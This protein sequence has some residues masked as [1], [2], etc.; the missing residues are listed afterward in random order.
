MAYN[1]R[2]LLERIIEIQDIVLAEKKRLIFQKTIYRDIIEPRY[3]IS[4]T[5]FCNYMCRNA[6]KELAE[7]NKKDKALFV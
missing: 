5:T 6:K 2:N 1:S 3:K 7:I 4:Y